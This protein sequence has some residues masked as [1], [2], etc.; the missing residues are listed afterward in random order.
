MNEHWFYK[1]KLAD[2]VS[3]SKINKLISSGLK[4]GAESAKLLGAGNGGFIMFLVN[5][6]KKEQLKKNFSKNL[7]VPVD[8]DLKGSEIIY[9]LGNE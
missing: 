7:I 1:K 6:S 8:F 4:S 2:E 3:N 5:E 9:S